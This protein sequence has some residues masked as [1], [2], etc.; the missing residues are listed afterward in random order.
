[1]LDLIRALIGARIEGD[2]NDSSTTVVLS[3]TPEAFLVV[4]HRCG[5][6]VVRV[7]VDTDPIIPSIGLTPLDG[8][9][10]KRRRFNRV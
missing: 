2:V 4:L 9:I 3:S 10:N 7:S 6:K 5:E 8:T 1:M